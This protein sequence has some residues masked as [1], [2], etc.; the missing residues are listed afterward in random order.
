MDCPKCVVLFSGK[1]KSGKDFVAERVFNRLGAEHAVIIR[2]SAPIKSHWAEKEGLSLAEL[3]GTSE[4]KE[5]YRKNMIK[6]GEEKRL[7]DPGYFCQAAI[8][9]TN[10]NLK[11]VWIISD[12]RRMTDLEWFQSHYGNSLLTVRIRADID[13]RKKRGWIFTQGV[14]D[15]ETE[16]GLDSVNSWN[17]IID[18]NHSEDYLEEK[19]DEILNWVKNKLSS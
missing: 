18:N 7:E 8:K 12:A 1:R 17:V 11:P 9:M 4:Y 14:D 5:T 2:L 10:A 6:W 15:A 16:C 19:I 3:M 13:V